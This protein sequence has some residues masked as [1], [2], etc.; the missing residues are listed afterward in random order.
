MGS[1]SARPA[2][3]LAGIAGWW[4]WDEWGGDGWGWGPEL[5]IEKG[6]FADSPARLYIWL[7]GCLVAGY[8][9]SY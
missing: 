7:G 8:E 9:A 1:R 5:A 3:E 2:W 4:G 6:W